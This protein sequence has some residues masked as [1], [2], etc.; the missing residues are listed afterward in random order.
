[1]MKRIINTLL[2]ATMALGLNA[3]V[4]IDRTKA[5]LPGPAPKLN[6]GKAINFQLENGLKVI[7]V[8]NHKL[9]KVSFQLTV[10]MDPVLEEDKVGYASMAGDLISA[11]TA[12]MTKSQIDEE[13]DFIGGSLSTFSNGMFA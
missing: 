10:D 9:P 3:Q 13:V 4:T 6:I 12:T 2:I 8:E 1:M 5:P 11:G 7:V